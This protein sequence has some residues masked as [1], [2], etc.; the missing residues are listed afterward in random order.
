MNKTRRPVIGLI[1]DMRDL[2][3]MPFQVLGDKYAQAVSEFAQALPLAILSERAGNHI[4][5]LVETFDGFL[6]TG[7]PSNIRP[8][9]YGQAGEGVGPFDDA[10][11]ELSLPLIRAA[12][13]AKMPI[14]SICRG[15]QE[16]NVAH[17]GTLHVELE[18]GDLHHSPEDAPYEDR[19][20]PLH[21][22]HL[23]PGSPLVR[24]FGAETFSVNSLHYQALAKIG[25]GLSVQGTAPDGIP[26]IV[27]VEGQPFAVGVQ[28]HPEYRP[29]LHD[30]NRAL[31]Q[32]FG[33][34]ARA[35]RA[36]RA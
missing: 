26:E 34:A 6:F 10:R 24:V 8:W 36:A 22:V 30:P 21:E 7:S 33:E 1:T 2:G 9:R 14:L 13:A 18:N 35:Y 15:L 20:A 25:E 11:D 31:F 29:D 17:G 23:R 16:L 12:L 32:S 28:W 3:G 4:G 19:Y 27:T 5:E